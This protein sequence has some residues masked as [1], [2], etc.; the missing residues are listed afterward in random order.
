MCCQEDILAAENESGDHVKIKEIDDNYL[1][2]YLKIDDPGPYEMKNANAAFEAAKSYV[3]NQ[4]GIEDE[5]L[6]SKDDL[7]IAVLILTEDMYDNRRY[8]VDTEKLNQVV[9]GIIYQYS[10]NLL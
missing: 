2:D 9:E 7:A 6:S 10:E 8:Y 1:A 5:A 4:T 3:K